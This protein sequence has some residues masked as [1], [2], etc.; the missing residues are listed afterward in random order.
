MQ[1][2]TIEN[3]SVV[4]QL[5]STFATHTRTHAEH[6]AKD[7][8]IKN[9]KD[10]AEFIGENLFLLELLEEIPEQ[11]RKIFGDV[12]SLKLEFF[13]DPEDQNYHRLSVGIPTKSELEKSSSLLKEFDENWW[14]KN[15]RKSLSKIL[16]DLEFIK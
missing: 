2:D 9:P 11:I 6:L 15:E 14:F 16:I 5:Q 3:V 13:F 12:Q 10:V 7:Y 1:L 4:E 8:I